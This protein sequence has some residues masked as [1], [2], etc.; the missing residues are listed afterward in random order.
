MHC[1]TCGSSIPA[2]A[3][4]CPNCGEDLQS[5]DETTSAA[6][7]P[8]AQSSQGATRPATTSKT[9]ICPECGTPNRVDDNFC[10]NCGE[11]LTAARPAGGTRQAAASAPSNGSTTR[12]YLITGVAIAAIALVVYL[13]AAPKEHAGPPEQQPA[14]AGNAQQNGALPPGHP[15]T[16]GQASTAEQE[17]TIA[18]LKAALANNPGDSV[19]QLKLANVLYDAGRHSDAVAAYRDY[20]KVHPDN[21]DARTDMAYSLYQTGDIDG[22]IA[23][24]KRVVESNGQHQTAGLN[25]A[26]MYVEKLS[27]SIGESRKRDSTSGASS[28][29]HLQDSLRMSGYRDSLFLW[30]N[31]V[32]A[33][34]STTPQGQRAT[35]ILAALKDAHSG[36]MAK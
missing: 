30:L 8:A 12:L 19:A 33:V 23:E 15:P 25:L 29:A 2:D 6:S 14:S 35:Q 34:D 22:S 32:V 11:P 18:D 13:L 24:L 16:G 9:K 10:S 17:K 7:V 31:R 5:I 4:V 21:G 3:T 20:L 28:P 1:P 26:M 27:R 36:M